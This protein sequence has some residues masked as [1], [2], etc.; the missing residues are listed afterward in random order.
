MG[1]ASNKNGLFVGPRGIYFGTSEI[2]Q[3]IDL[4]TALRC[5]N[6][7]NL[8]YVTDILSLKRTELL[9]EIRKEELKKT[10][11]ERDSWF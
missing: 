7:R 1:N 10:A 8:N 4:H 9:P 3:D 6:A 11:I 5:R 2:N